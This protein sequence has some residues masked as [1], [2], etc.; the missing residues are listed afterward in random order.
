MSENIADKEFP[1]H[2]IDCGP[3]VLFFLVGSLFGTSVTLLLRLTSP[4]LLPVVTG[5]CGMS[6]VVIPWCYYWTA[7]AA[8]VFVN[9]AS[10]GFVTTSKCYYSLSIVVC[11]CNLEYIQFYRVST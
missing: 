7:L 8:A 5:V 6:I 1:F 2:N 11:K 4:C 9:G 3:Y 10:V